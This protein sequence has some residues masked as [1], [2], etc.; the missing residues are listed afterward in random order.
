MRE[1]GKVGKVHSRREGGCRWRNRAVF[2]E[3]CQKQKI[4]LYSMEVAI[5]NGVGNGRWC[6]P[7]ADFSKRPACPRT[8]CIIGAVATSCRAA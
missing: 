4:E 1:K 2:N 8:V 5:H 6:A 7:A 3:G